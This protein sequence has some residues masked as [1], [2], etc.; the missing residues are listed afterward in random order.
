MRYSLIVIIAANPFVGFAHFTN[1][2]KFQ[3]ELRFSTMISAQENLFI[4]KTKTELTKMNASC[5]LMIF[6]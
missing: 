5:R 6:A 3:G 2:I 1:K 4:Q